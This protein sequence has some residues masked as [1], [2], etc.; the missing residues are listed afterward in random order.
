L[1]ANPRPIIEPLIVVVAVANQRRSVVECQAFHID[2]LSIGLHRF[3]TQS[4][5]LMASVSRSDGNCWSNFSSKVHPAESM[6]SMLT[7]R[8]EQQ[9]TVPYFHHRHHHYR[10]RRSRS[11]TCLDVIGRHG[12]SLRQGERFDRIVSLVGNTDID[13]A[14]KADIPL[15]LPMSIIAFQGLLACCNTPYRHCRLLSHFSTL[16]LLLLLLRWCGRCA[17]V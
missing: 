14:A 11:T 5:A 12:P 1:G 15:L 7:N 17:R 9:A 16:L 4:T 3:N 10:R 6:R 8:R 2:L 13:D